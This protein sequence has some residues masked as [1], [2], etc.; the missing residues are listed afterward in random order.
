MNIFIYLIYNVTKLGSQN[1]SNEVGDYNKK[2]SATF[3]ST[4][5]GGDYSRTTLETGMYINN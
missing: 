3:G 4:V 1:T 5:T 2:V